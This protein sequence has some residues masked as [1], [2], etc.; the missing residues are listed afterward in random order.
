MNF[1]KEFVYEKIENVPEC[2]ASTVLP[3]PDGRVMV[4]WFAGEH[5]KNDNVR[6]WFSV[7][8]NGKWTEPAKVP[9]EE[10]VPHWNPVLDMKNDGIIRL[11][12]KKGK[13]INEWVTW[14]CD[15]ADGGKTWSEAEVLVPDDFSGGRGPVKNKCIRTSQGLLLAPASSEKTKHWRCFIDVSRD[16][17]DTWTRCDFI[18]R[19]RKNIGL[20][21]MIQPTLWEDDD[22]NIHALMRTDKGRIYK[23]HSYDGGLTWSKAERTELPNNNSGIDCV[24][25]SD[26]KIYLVY[27]PV[28]E[29]WG[30][31]SPL[32]LAVSEDNGETFRTVLV[33][34]NEK[35]GEFSYPAITCYNNKLHITY[36]YNRKKIRYCEVGL[37]KE[38]NN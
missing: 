37:M 25:A 15:S 30:D 3:L 36:T 18:V 21:R 32:E 35:D 20:V 22:K 28:E 26:G 1:K 27:N 10:N 38:G 16:D 9:S 8:E 34:E 24:R 6:I 11:Y 14:F 31:R 17:G 7:N 19:P 23:S 29:N 33:L 12:F 5:E 13:E 4:A 2:H